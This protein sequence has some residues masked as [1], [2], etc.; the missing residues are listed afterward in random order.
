MRVCWVPVVCPAV[1]ALVHVL[2]LHSPPDGGARPREGCR[3]GGSERKRLAQNHMDDG[4]GDRTGASALSEGTPRA[5]GPSEGRD[6]DIPRVPTKLP[7]P[8]SPR[9]GGYES[10]SQFF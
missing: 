1:G 2:S 9:Y 7:K 6:S 3:N 10:Y 4:W 5:Q 8:H